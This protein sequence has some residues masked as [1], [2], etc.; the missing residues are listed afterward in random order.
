MTACLGYSLDCV[1]NPDVLKQLP[2]KVQI[3]E[4]KY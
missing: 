4:N 2:T 1:G 3:S